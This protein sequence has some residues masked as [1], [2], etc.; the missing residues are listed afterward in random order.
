MRG[1]RTAAAATTSNRVGGRPKPAK[2]AVDEITSL[3][4]A[5]TEAEA[6]AASGVAA[7]VVAKTTKRLLVVLLRYKDELRVPHSA[8]FYRALIN[9]LTG[10]DALAIPATVNGYYDK[11]AWG[12]IGF[13]A[14]IAGAGGQ[15]APSGWF[16]LPH[17]RATYGNDI[18]A[19]ADDAMALVAAARIDVSGYDSLSFITSNDFGTSAKGGNYEYAGKVY[20]ATWI[21][22]W[23]Q[24]AET[25]VHELGHSLG[26]PHSGWVYH[27]YDN[28][29][30]D[31]SLGS[32]AKEVVCGWYYSAMNDR[33]R[34]D[35]RCKEP[36]GG[37]ITMHK[38]YKGWLPA[39]NIATIDAVGQTTVV[40]EANALPLGTAKKMVKICLAGYACT[41]ST[42]R[43]FTVEARIRAAKYE[44]GLPGEG[45]IINDIK[46][47]R[48]PIGSGN[49]CYYN[50]QSGWALPIDATPGDYDGYYCDYGDRQ[51]PNYGLYNA[52]F[53][54]GKSF[55][56]NSKGIKVEVL[57]RTTTTFTVR[58]TRS[59]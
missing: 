25:Y 32:A 44:M 28:P 26:L 52:Q 33:E 51:K 22:P 45:V 49:A 41:G 15:G 2:L 35:I 55:V 36:G 18:D 43:Y 16:V 20:G 24:E 53:K 1:R 12:R 21:P 4:P 50:T 27:A 38:A 19:I 54:V 10:N 13:A 11:V 56:S 40:L 7:P 31:M 47:N 9:P 46:M 30:D 29:W 14:D 34:T 57:S 3:E 37:F 5:A 17:S 6:P 39:A 59:L 8:A 48:S 58:I 42:A 23:A